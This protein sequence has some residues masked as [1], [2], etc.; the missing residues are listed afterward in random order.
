VLYEHADVLEVAVVGRPHEKWGEV[1]VAY[2]VLRA[3]ATV[4][5]AGIIAHVRSKIAPFKAPKQVVFA[6]LPKTSTGKI[7]KNVLRAGLR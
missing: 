3:G 5:E 7:Q 2:V 6:D 1:P 4:D